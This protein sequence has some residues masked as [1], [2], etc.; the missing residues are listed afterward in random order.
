MIAGE[1]EE[2]VEAADL[3]E[4]SAVGGFAARRTQRSSGL[5]L[6]VTALRTVK[7]SVPELAMAASSDTSFAA[8]RSVAGRARRETRWSRRAQ[9]LPT[10]A[11]SER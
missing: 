4:R 9:S 1:A 3:P 7:G 10:S 2:P 11:A 5:T 6:A 8:T